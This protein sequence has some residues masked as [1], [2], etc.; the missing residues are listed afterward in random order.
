MS[1]QDKEPAYVRDT[2][3]YR[4]V[5][6]SLGLVAVG[7]I[8]GLLAGVSDGKDALIAIGSAS[9]P[10]VPASRSSIMARAQ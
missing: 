3:F 9:R 4:G 5:V 6:F 1:D 8:V 10:G 7:S 2:W